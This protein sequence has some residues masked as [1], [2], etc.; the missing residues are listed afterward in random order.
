MFQITDP[1]DARLASVTPRVEKHGDDEVPA[2][3]IALEIEAANT[4]L[5]LID[6]TIRQALY[7]AKGD[8]T[9]ELPGVEASTPVLRCNSIDSV[10]LITSHEGWTL[11]VHHSVDERAAP[12][13]FGGV[14]VD[15]FRVEA[16]QGGTVVLRIRCGTSDVDAE[17]IGWLGVHNGQYIT[18]SLHAPKPGEA[19]AGEG[20]GAR[21]PDATDLFAAGGPGP[22]AGAGGGDSE[23]GETNGHAGEPSGANGETVALEGE[24]QRGENWPFPAGAADGSSD[25]ERSARARAGEQPPQDATHERLPKRRGKGDG[26]A[27]GVH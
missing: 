24:P 27:A 3:S 9:P 8:D 10:K 18:V 5:D 25:E 20:D 19:S 4:L 6:P 26:A 13:A 16:K 14:K 7:K 2:V 15:Q 22:R 21:E 11:H 17:R 12:L 1:T 23:G